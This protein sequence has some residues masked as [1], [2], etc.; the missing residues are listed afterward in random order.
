M[1]RTRWIVVAVIVAVLAVI[2]MRTH[3]GHEQARYRTVAAERGAIESRVSATGTI[4]PK[5]QVE[6]GS[7]V[8]GT[9]QKIFADYNS[10][11]RRG[12]IL[13]QIEPSTFRAR[14]LQSEAAVAR[15]EAALKDTQRQLRRAKE[16]VGKDYI[17]Q[18]ELESAEATVDQR[19]ADL[20]QANA[21][22][23]ASRVDL[24]NTTIRAPIDGVVISRSI[25]V[26]QTV[27]ASLQAPKLF[28]LANDLAQMQVETS[29]DEADI[30]QIRVGLPVS[31]TVD[32]FQDMAFEGRVSQVRL[33]P[34]VQQGVV[35]YTTVIGAANPSLKLRPGMTANVS[36]LI[37][38]RDDV[39]RIPAAALRFRPPGEPV[40]LPVVVRGAAGARAPGSHDRGAA[41]ERASGSHDRGAWRA[42]AR[43][44]GD[45]PPDVPVDRPGSVYVLRA[46]KVACVHVLTGL[47]DGT[48]VEVRS[49]S[50]R[51]GDAVITGIEFSAGSTNLQ[52]P[53]GMGGP[54]F[55]GPMGRGGGVGGRR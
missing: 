6:V 18:A 16:L 54:Q 26:G 51:A 1:N 25:D 10:R 2:W 55:R 13:L 49:G 3:G 21:Q 20:K 4:R 7:Q 27:A 48:S 24:A 43:P 44:Q 38:R 37:E 45:A 23:E 52:P 42:G 39:L 33:E 36:V 17:S 15:A 14:E 46:G 41:G 30:G 34:I 53:P 40:M 28:V 22:L 5:V 19:A 12:E 32:A 9:V 50:L 47:G 35:T 29:I 8:S 11:V 31:F